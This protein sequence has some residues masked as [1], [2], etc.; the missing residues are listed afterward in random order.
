MCSTASAQHHHNHFMDMPDFQSAYLPERIV[1]IPEGETVAMPSGDIDLLWIEGTCVAPRGAD[2]SLRVREIVV[3]PSGKLDMGTGADPLLGK[4]TITWANGELLEND[5][6]QWGVGLLVF[7]EFNACGIKRDT[8]TENAVG[9]GWKDDDKIVS[10]KL[11]ADAL[12]VIGPLQAN[13]SSNV[14]FQSEDP[15]GTRGHIIITDRAETSICHVA[16]VGMGRTKP[17]PLS[18]TNL[19]G[20][21][22]LHFHHS[23]GKR[24]EVKSVIA[25][26]L[27]YRSKWG[28]V[29]H[30]SSWVTIEDCVATK[31]GGAGFVTED[32]SE[33]GNRFVGNLAFD[34]KPTMRQFPK[35]VHEGFQGVGFWFK[36]MVQY[37]DDNVA[38]DNWIGFQS[39]VT[40]PDIRGVPEPGQRTSVPQQKYQSSPGGMMDGVVTVF[41]SNL[42]GK[43]NRFIGNHNVGLENWGSVPN[44]FTYTAP[45]YWRLNALPVQ[46]EDCLFAFNAIQHGG[47]EAA[48]SFAQ[49]CVLYTNCEFVS[50]GGRFGSNSSIDYH[51]VLYFDGCSFDGMKTGLVTG[52]GMIVENCTFN[53]ETSVLFDGVTSQ[54][55]IY[56]VTLENNTHAGEPAAY[57]SMD[58]AGGMEPE[59]IKP[60][61]VT[62]DQVYANVQAYRDSIAGSHD[63]NESERQR[64]TAE[65][66]AIDSQI[67]S[68]NT[69]I[70]SLQTLRDELQRQLFELQ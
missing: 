32:G 60:H 7:G 49:S 40:S 54:K 19:I 27:D 29:V 30:G 61:E 8:W 25:D 28:I 1:T 55:W 51:R 46:W 62:M 70:G 52:R 48:H 66:A 57:V 14:T 12:T 39:A 20:R 56:G 11:T 36:S 4:V 64:L 47:I 69:E 24:R 18:A 31:F 43:R 34:N 17:E 13:L 22:P 59:D 23:M 15:A 63:G 50:R 41:Q 26:G 3:A 35:D 33:V 45:D 67:E 58:F 9:E 38:V 68:L 44:F 21:Y 5:V 16:L 37:I 10:P 2:L 65:I 6:E 42:S 53:T